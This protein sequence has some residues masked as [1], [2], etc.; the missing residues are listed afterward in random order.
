MSVKGGGNTST[1]L[2]IYY[3]NACFAQQSAIELVTT[4]LALLFIL[5]I[6][7]TEFHFFTFSHG[8]MF[9]LME[10]VVLSEIFCHVA[11]LESLYKNI[12][13]LGVLS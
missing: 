4:Y 2:Y 12:P 1:H 9:M 6:W 10:F 8:E 11:L 13:S 7:H 3:T 5:R